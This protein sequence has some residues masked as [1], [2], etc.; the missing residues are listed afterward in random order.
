MR[1][2]SFENPVRAIEESDTHLAISKDS[3]TVTYGASH[4]T[5]KAR[6]IYARGDYELRFA[7]ALSIKVP[8]VPRAELFR[9]ISS[10]HSWVGLR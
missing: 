10:C 4:K 6:I 5:A 2:D 9:L 8:D 1:R 7:G 3:Y